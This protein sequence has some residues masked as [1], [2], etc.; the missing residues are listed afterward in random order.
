MATNDSRGHAHDEHDRPRCREAARPE[1]AEIDAE[2]A[3]RLDRE[4]ERGAS[5][6]AVLQHQAV[7]GD[8][9]GQRHHHQLRAA[10]PQRRDADDEA[11]RAGTQHRQDRGHGNG[12][13]RPEVSPARR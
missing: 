10:D 9:E 13:W 1:R 5:E 4:A 11:E 12:T 6:L 3:S 7:D 2:E 8:R